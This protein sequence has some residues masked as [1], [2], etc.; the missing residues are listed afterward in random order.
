MSSILKFLTS[1]GVFCA[2]S[3]ASIAGAAD[4]S[5]GCGPGWYV[6]KENSLVSS[7]L[8]STTNGFLAP[9]V[10]LGMTSGT[11]NCTQH[12]IV[13][14][15]KE[16]L[17]FASMNYYE[18]KRD[19]AKGEGEYLSAFATTIGCPAQAQA[20]FNQKVRGSYGEVF[21][22]GAKVDAES[23]LLEVYK[24]ILSDKELTAQCSLGHVG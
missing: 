4:G 18:L 17:H 9:V 20:R 12:K 14:K 24:I 7:A 15:E 10:T 23:A 19:A 16:S 21:R 2:G 3:V 22:A 5:S 1:I 11:S 13:L 8:R 6:F